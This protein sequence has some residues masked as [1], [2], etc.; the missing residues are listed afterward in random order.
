MESNRKTGDDVSGFCMIHLRPRLKAV[1]SLI[2]P[3]LRVADIG[4]DHG[5]LA[6]WLKANGA[7]SV[8]AADLRPGPLEAARRS[9]REY[10]MEKELSFVLSDGF[11]KLDT[12]ALDLAVIAGMGG[13]T[14]AAILSRLSPAERAHIR[15]VLQPQSKEEE[16]CR[17]LEELG[18]SLARAAAVR[19]AG[20]LYVAFSARY[21]GPG[22]E[23][24]LY[25]ALAASGTEEA[26]S[27]LKKREKHLEN[28]YAGHLRSGRAEEGA[29]TACLL[30]AV[31]EAISHI[32]TK[33]SPDFVQNQD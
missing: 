8:V 30:T 32:F 2:S 24:R 5:L 21:T 28:E 12:E 3:G 25:E 26:V 22:A 9:A 1:A 23:C 29:G 17:A 14:I 33:D 11:E 6:L 10:G 20:R 16:L 19:D 31:R 27:W 7:N 15:L 4:T 18:Y 13:E